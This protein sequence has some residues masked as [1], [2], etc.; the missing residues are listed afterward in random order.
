MLYKSI[1]KY[2]RNIEGKNI[3]ITGAGTG[4]GKEIAIGLSALGAC[5]MLVGRTEK[6][7]SE[8][9]QACHAYSQKQGQHNTEIYYY[10][11]D[12]SIWEQAQQVIT[13]T[14]A[15]LSEIDIVI[16]NAGKSM[17]API[18]ECM[19]GVFNAMINSNYYTAVN[20]I[21][22]SLPH[23]IKRK[24][25]ICAVTSI[26]AII[27]VP[28]HAAYV[29]AKHAVTGYLETL[30]LEHPE[31]S[32]VELLPGWIRGT[33]LRSNAIDGMG[34]VIIGRDKH[35]WHSRSSVSVDKCAH[36]AI[37]A[38]AQKKRFTY[39]PE[40]WKNTRFI[41]LFFRNILK[42]IIIKRQSHSSS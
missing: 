12:V 13:Y 4:L 3:L 19:S 14:Q 21:Q 22:H 29:A 17:H 32:I 20:V 9:V 15:K 8:S 25:I 30:E 1:A 28:N 39:T 36:T 6:T 42:K 24:G 11:A 35:K 27:G 18:S 23:I 31:I 37:S 26:Q 16:A 5:L 41:K 2:R 10:K 38:I 33:A 34:N 40:F 7:L